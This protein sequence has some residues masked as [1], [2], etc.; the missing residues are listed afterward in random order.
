MSSCVCILHSTGSSCSRELISQAVYGTSAVFHSII[1][2][3][4]DFI[5]TVAVLRANPIEGVRYVYTSCANYAPYETEEEEKEKEKKEEEEENGDRRKVRR[6]EA[7]ISAGATETGS[8][9]Q[10]NGLRS[11]SVLEVF[12]GRSALGLQRAIMRCASDDVDNSA[13]VRDGTDRWGSG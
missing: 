10:N 1:N 4:P 5:P 7:A 9:I 12:A 3:S 8:S 6:R 13:C 2:S 11:Q